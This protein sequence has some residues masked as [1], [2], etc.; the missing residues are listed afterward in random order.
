MM[1]R[2]LILALCLSFCSCSGVRII[3]PYDEVIDK[4]VVSFSEQFNA[5]VKNMGDLGGTQ[6]G[7]YAANMRTYNDLDAKLDVLIARSAAAS[8][9]LGC[10]VEQKLYDQLGKLLQTDI[11][12]DLR[13][14]AATKTGNA[15]GCNEKLLVLVKKQLGSIKEIHQKIDKCGE[16]DLSCLRPATV[17]TA[18]KIANQSVN[19]V[20][21]VE[22][23]KKK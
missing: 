22:T 11:P 20:S 13:A 2:L 6:E 23:A 14:D 5:F 12:P 10:K 21:V 9:G 1:K 4:G 17:E 16:K 7:T 19:A 3:N 8:Q 15:E 18:L